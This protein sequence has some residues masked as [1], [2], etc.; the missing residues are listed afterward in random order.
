M[1]LLHCYFALKLCT[2]TTPTHVI[3]S[4]S[5]FEL[6]VV[7]MSWKPLLSPVR[8]QISVETIYFLA[9]VWANVTANALSTICTATGTISERC[10]DKTTHLP[11]IFLW[12]EII[13]FTRQTVHFTAH[14]QKERLHSDNCTR[15]IKLRWSERILSYSANADTRP[16]PAEVSIL[17]SHRS[18]LCT[19]VYPN[20]LQ[21]TVRAA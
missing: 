8:C 13:R 9:G 7:K 15:A 10:S 14:L 5:C 4:H 6:Y 19:T 3:I 1:E 18:V 20:L 2:A 17:F 11:V 16:S 21:N 12:R